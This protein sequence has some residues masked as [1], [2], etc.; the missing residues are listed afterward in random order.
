MTFYLL[1]WTYFND[2]DGG[3]NILINSQLKE[4]FLWAGTRKNET[5]L[6]KTEKTW[7]KK[8]TAMKVRLQWKWDTTFKFFEAFEFEPKANIGDIKSR[9]SDDEEDGAEYK[10]K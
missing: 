2:V 9:S 10:V 3:R 6:R 5:K 7:K 1:T 8:I 4:S